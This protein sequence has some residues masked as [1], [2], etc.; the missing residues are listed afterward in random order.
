M[1][2]RKQDYV[3]VYEDDVFQLQSA[4]KIKIKQLYNIILKN[5]LSNLI[6]IPRIAKFCDEPDIVN[7][8]KVFE[9]IYKITQYTKHRTFHFQF[10]HDI[11]VNNYWLHKWKLTEDNMC[12]FCNEDEEDISHLFWECIFSRQF[13]RDFEMFYC[14]SQKFT[15]ND[16]FLGVECKYTTNYIFLARNF[17]FK[18]R[19]DNITPQLRLFHSYANTFK[20]LEFEIARK[21]NKLDDWIEVWAVSSK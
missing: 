1:G 21:K 14:N 8:N 20:N 6:T 2:I 7:W 15:K 17:I 18:C 9:R 5:K 3:I 4:D 11:L 10:L 16:V 12:S 13:W 19:L